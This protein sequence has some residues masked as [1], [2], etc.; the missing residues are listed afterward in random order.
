MGIKRRDS[1]NR[2]LHNGESQRKDGRY[3]YKYVDNAG[4]TKYL[5]SWRL[6]GTDPLPKG[7]RSDLPLRDK[8]K[9]LQRDLDDG[10][11]LSRGS[12]TVLEL[13]E[14]YTGQK[15]GVRYSTQERYKYVLSLLRN[16]TFGGRRIDRVKR[17]DAKEWFARLQK[18]GRG[19]STIHR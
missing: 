3:M 8:I 4:D 16:D 10:I 18:G 2:V 13:V 5:Y 11:D 1:R 9:M 12:M 7:A 6:V 15:T 14:K 19:Y 17:S